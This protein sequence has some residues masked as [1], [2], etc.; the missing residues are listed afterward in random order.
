[1]VSVVAVRSVSVALEDVQADYNQAQYGLRFA[2]G[3]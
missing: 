1:M 2:V 3:D